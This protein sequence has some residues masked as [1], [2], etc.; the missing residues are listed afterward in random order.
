MRTLEHQQFKTANVER[1]R[2]ES[3]GI[4][5]QRQKVREDAEAAAATAMRSREA[6]AQAVMPSAATQA[7]APPATRHHLPR[8]VITV[9]AAAAVFGLGYW[10]GLSDPGVPQLPSVVR[11]D[12]PIQLQLRFDRDVDALSRRHGADSDFGSEK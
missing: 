8:L 12:M 5:L 4:A 6:A 7:A 3:E 2:A 1:Q 10:R 11:T 9:V